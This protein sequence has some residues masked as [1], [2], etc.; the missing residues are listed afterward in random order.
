MGYRGMFRVFILINRRR[1]SLEG[2]GN[3]LGGLVVGEL[4]FNVL[5]EREGL[6]LMR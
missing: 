3:L 5:G 2:W 1:C 4:G 6:G